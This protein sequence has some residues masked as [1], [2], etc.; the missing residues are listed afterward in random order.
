[1][2]HYTNFNYLAGVTVN[3]ITVNSDRANTERVYNTVIPT[4][5]ILLFGV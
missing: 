1:M 5:Y 2:G 4:H 3:G